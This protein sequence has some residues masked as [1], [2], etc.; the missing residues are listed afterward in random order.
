MEI[1]VEGVIGSYFHEFVAYS[2]VSTRFFIDASMIADL[3]L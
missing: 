2:A 3:V 1:A